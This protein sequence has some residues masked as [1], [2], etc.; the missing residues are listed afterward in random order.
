MDRRPSG[1]M[2]IYTLGIVRLT[3]CLVDQGPGATVMTERTARCMDLISRCPRG[4]AVHRVPGV[5]VCLVHVVTGITIGRYGE[6]MSMA[7]VTG[8]PGVMTGCA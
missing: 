3:D 6:V 8:G 5:T 7:V 1:S 2:T 4:V